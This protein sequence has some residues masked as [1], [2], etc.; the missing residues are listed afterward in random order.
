MQS[1]ATNPSRQYEMTPF[2]KDTFFETATD[3]DESTC[4]TSGLFSEA[5]DGDFDRTHT[6]E[7]EL[8]HFLYD[9]VNE[10]LLS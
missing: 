6:M 3:D 7:E 5:D 9:F 4:T 1:Q 2:S 8:N 10:V